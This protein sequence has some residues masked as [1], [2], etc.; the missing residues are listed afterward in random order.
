MKIGVVKRDP[1][2]PVPL[3]T[4]GSI[5]W[6]EVTRLLNL[7]DVPE[8]TPFLVPDDGD[9]GSVQFTNSY[10]LDASRQD[11]Y[12]SNGL[13]KHHVPVLRRLLVFLRGRHGCVDLT[14]ATRADLVAYRDFRRPGLAPTS[15]NGELSVLAGFYSYAKRRGWVDFDPVPRWGARQRNTLRD[16]VN[17]HRRERFLTEAQTRLFLEVGLRGDSPS[18][19]E[20]RPRHAERNY[21]IG[22]MLVSTGLRRQEATL[23]LDCEVPTS[24]TLHPSGIESFVRFGK[25]GRPRA[26]WVTDDLVDAVDMYRAMEREKIVRQSQRTLRK[27]MRSG[28]VL[29]VDEIIPNRRGHDIRVGQ[30][31]IGNERFSD[32]DRTRAVIV[33]PDGIINPI[34]LFVVEGGRPP[35]LRTVNNIFNEALERVA[36]IDHPDRPPAHLDVTP[37]VMRHTFAVR[38]LAALMRQGRQAGGDPYELLASPI[39]VVQQLLGHADVETTL[40]YLYAAERY[41]EQLPAALRQSVA[42]SLAGTVQ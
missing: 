8:G 25:G 41:T 36:S 12:R 40:R 9:L 3:P 35:A 19:T 13:L 15:W 33:R 29:V 22:L 38:M 20:L 42:A 16:R 27:R 14:A 17:E 32:E 5:E 30:H 31:V 28:D 2:G 39:V 37:H 7:S 26:V 11:A 23:L 10:L 24:E 6:T 21:A 34:T 18:T 4:G 1:G